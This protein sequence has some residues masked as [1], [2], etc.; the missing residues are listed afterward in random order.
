M[1]LENFK[2]VQLFSMCKFTWGVIKSEFSHAGG[3]ATDRM[4]ATGVDQSHKYSIQA[5]YKGL[6]LPM[7]E[8]RD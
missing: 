3:N 5:S 1:Q 4:G 7:T 8:V 6:W 2:L